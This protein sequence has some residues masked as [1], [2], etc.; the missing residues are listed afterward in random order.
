MSIAEH[1][2]EIVHAPELVARVVS[3]PWEV[4]RAVASHV[5]MV[6]RQPI[7][8]VAH[9]RSFAARTGPAPL[10][11]DSQLFRGRPAHL[12]VLFC[13]RS[14]A[15]G[16]ET[17][18]LDGH[19]LLRRVQTRDPALY[20]ALFSTPRTLPFVFGDVVA[21]TASVVGDDLVI[22]YPPVA[23]EPIGMALAEHVAAMPRETV[24]L[25]AGDVLLVDNHRMLHGRT[26]FE[27]P[28]RALERLLIWRER[29]CV[30]PADLLARARS[31]HPPV[32]VVDATV[33]EHPNAHAIVEA[34]L[35]GT[36]PGVLAVQ[37]GIPESHLYAFRDRLAP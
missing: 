27:D 9:G 7:R 20:E 13:V 10:H 18:L 23:R 19:A 3:T 6:E 32:R 30:A 8:P 26:S 5:T 22:T 16:G 37:H 36:P 12:Q 21:S 11:T 2:F 1:G 17:T 35:A 34:M 14:A 33:G 15:V 24:A 29:G 4:A 25:R 31:G 28:S